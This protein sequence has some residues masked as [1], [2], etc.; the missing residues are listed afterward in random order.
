MTSD[1]AVCPHGENLL[2]VFFAGSSRARSATAGE[3]ADTL[4]SPDDSP[5]TAIVKAVVSTYMHP[6]LVAAILCRLD[7]P[8]LRIRIGSTTY[9]QYIKTPANHSLLECVLRLWQP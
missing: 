2:M 9:H 4:P 8:T 7:F 5:E 3:L 1:G 6:H